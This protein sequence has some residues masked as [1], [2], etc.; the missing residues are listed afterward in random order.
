MSHHDKFWEKFGQK[1][2]QHQPDAY[3]P[4]E[5]NAMEELL[6]SS[7]AAGSS[8]RR[9]RALRAGVIVLAITA[10]YLAGAWYGLPGSS[11]RLGAFPIP[12]PGIAAGINE[13]GQAEKTLD[14]TSAGTG[15]SVHAGR[16]SREGAH[17]PMEHSPALNP[18]KSRN[19]TDGMPF[20]SD[21]LPANA[22]N[23]PLP[24]TAQEAQARG[25]SPVAPPAYL[26]SAPK[27]V[28]PLAEAILAGGP[29]G[30]AKKQ[31]PIYGGFLLGANHAVISLQ[32]A[33]YSTHPFGGLFGGLKLSSRWA[34]Q[35]EA[36][37]KYVDNIKAA[38]EQMVTLESNNGFAFDQFSYGVAEKNY[39]ALEFPVVAKYRIRPAWSLL[40]GL[41]GGLAFDGVSFFS[42]SGKKNQPD[43]P[44]ANSNGWPSEGN[45]YSQLPLRRFNLGL[46]GGV[47]WA[48]HPRWSLDAR[49][50]QGLQDLSPGKVFQSDDKHFN[51]DFQISIRRKF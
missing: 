49:F 19:A 32:E 46:A 25:H 47:E 11:P 20:E 34:V 2:R 36:H 42:S 43:A 12:L 1:I 50:T 21:V 29:A 3:R 4:G 33:S 23:P 48:F 27:Q 8:F 16:R 35:L 7:K 31:N 28:L 6:E 9:S 22:A 18:D 24:E 26:P 15:Y 14:T 17:L 13:K 30:K 41:R 38:Y 40:G 5:W 39:L 44:T 51:S 45:S 37:L 10:G